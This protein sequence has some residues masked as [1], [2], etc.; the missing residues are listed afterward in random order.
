[1]IFKKKLFPVCILF[2]FCVPVLSC[3]VDTEFT[4]K[5]D[6]E[7]QFVKA[8]ARPS[9]GSSPLTVSFNPAG[10][11]IIHGNEL[12]YL[13]DFDNSRTSSEPSPEHTYTAM[14]TYMVS[15]M[16][17]HPNGSSDT[18]WTIVIVN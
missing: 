17:T 13:W 18:A 2:I 4:A 10:T 5:D 8:E 1:M 9:L 15:L 11:W 7:G 14:G 12:S 3:T 6:F 16:V